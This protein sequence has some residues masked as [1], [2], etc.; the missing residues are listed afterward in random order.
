MKISPDL[1]L[2]NGKIITVDKAF[3]IKETL[4]IKNE[5]I[6]FAGSKSDLRNQ[7]LP[8]SQEIDLKGLTVIP[9]SSILIFI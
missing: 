3:S 6:V 2:F 7:C 5:K 9:G 8:A 1:I 4:A